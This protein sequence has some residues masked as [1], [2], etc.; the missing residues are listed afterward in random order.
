MTQVR[1]LLE[2]TVAEPAQLVLQVGLAHGIGELNVRS[3]GEPMRAEHIGAGQMLVTADAGSLSVSY[4]GQAD[5]LSAQPAASTPASRVEALRPSRYCPSDRIAGYAGSRFGY[6][7]GALD[8]VR[9]VCDHVA[10]HLTYTVGSSAAT[11]DA[12][13]TLVSGAGVCRDYAHLVA[14]LCRAMGVPARV[15]S[16]YAPGLDPM[17]FHLVVEADIDGRWWAWDATRL[18]A[19][20]S[21]ARIATGRDAADVAFGTVVSGHVDMDTMEII[22]VADGDLPTDDHRCLVALS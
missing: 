1:A 3:N 4:L 13:D 19:R 9:A 8:T 14:A 16:V 15:A 22:A 17:D 21:L 6:Y 5:L 18:A 2:Y 7:S 20:Q 12:V 10:E 11:T